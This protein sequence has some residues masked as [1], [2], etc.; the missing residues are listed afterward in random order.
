MVES[1]FTNWV[2]VYTVFHHSQTCIIAYS[3]IPIVEKT[4]ARQK[5]CSSCIG[6]STVYAIRY[7]HFL[8]LGASIFKHCSKIG[9]IKHPLQPRHY[10]TNKT[11]SPVKMSKSSKV[12][13][14]TSWFLHLTHSTSP[15]D[16]NKHNTSK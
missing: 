16:I 4:S 12:V 10:K 13:S 14:W 15:L 9:T 5:C 7:I 6:Y 8:S 3:I 2:N 11:R 1:F